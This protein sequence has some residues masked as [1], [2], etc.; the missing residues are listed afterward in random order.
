MKI[1]NSTLKFLF[2]NYSWHHV[3]QFRPI[4]EWKGTGY[5]KY[6]LE[7]LNWKLPWVEKKKVP[8][9][10]DAQD[11]RPLSRRECNLGTVAILRFPIEG[12]SSN[13]VGVN[14]PR[15]EIPTLVLFFKKSFT[16]IFFNLRVDLFI[17]FLFSALLSSISFV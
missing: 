4:I 12:D 14:R 15:P 2:Y 1:Y 11:G 8:Q 13:K 7:N 3:P 10:I 17:R 9:S 6:H 5:C 16:C